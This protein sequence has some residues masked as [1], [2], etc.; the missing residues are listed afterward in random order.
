LILINGAVSPPLWVMNNSK[1]RLRIVSG[2]E[3]QYS[4][5][6]SILILVVFSSL[7]IAAELGIILLFSNLVLTDFIEMITSLH[8]QDHHNCGTK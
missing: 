4:Y 1:E 7:V 6:V 5:F 3:T 8:S 2:T